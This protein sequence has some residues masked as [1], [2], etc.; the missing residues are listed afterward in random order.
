MIFNSYN[1]VVF[2]SNNL[3]CFK[4]YIKTRYIYDRLRGIPRGKCR[5]RPRFRSYTDMYNNACHFYLNKCHLDLPLDPLPL[6]VL[7]CKSIHS[8]NT[9]VKTARVSKDA[10]KIATP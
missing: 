3:N 5:G 4:T 10:F 8:R 9:L 2:A 7:G 6:D 1:F